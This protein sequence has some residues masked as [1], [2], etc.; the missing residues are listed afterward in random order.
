MAI[1]AGTGSKVKQVK[2]KG[3]TFEQNTEIAGQ[4]LKMLRD[5]ESVSEVLATK[6][7]LLA[8]SAQPKEKAEEK[9]AGL[10][11]LGE[12]AVGDWILRRYTKNTYGYVS[13]DGW[14]FGSL[15]EAKDYGYLSVRGKGVS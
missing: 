10:D 12:E 11:L 8:E 5:G 13:P 3:A 2:R 15:S 14:E 1:V 4:L 6:D 7:R 9:D